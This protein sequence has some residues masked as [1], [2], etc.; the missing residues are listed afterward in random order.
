M[1]SFFLFVCLTLVDSCT[2]IIMYECLYFLTNLFSFLCHC[3][4]Y[5]SYK[6]L[7]F[8]STW[9]SLLLFIIVFDMK[10]DVVGL[11]SFILVYAICLGFL[12]LLAFFSS[13][14]WPNVLCTCSFYPSDM[15]V[16]N[17][18]F[19]GLVV[20]LIFQKIVAPMSFYQCQ[21]CYRPCWPSPWKVRDLVHLPIF[22]TYVHLQ[23]PKIFLV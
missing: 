2:V 6:S 17:S 14:L 15:K 20:T 22:P 1:D 5:V 7:M 19:N 21:E 4:R 16:V 3:S 18:V 13:Y 9:D 11:I 10:M 12:C 8:G 23:L